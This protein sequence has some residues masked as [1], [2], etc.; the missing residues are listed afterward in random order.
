MKFLFQA[1]LLLLP[2]TIYAESAEEIRA[3]YET[4]RRDGF[5]KVHEDYV[6]KLKAAQKTLLTSQQLE[7]ANAIQPEIE[8]VGGRVELFK[9]GENPAVPGLIPTGEDSG[10]QSTESTDVIRSEETE[11]LRGEFLDR[12]RRGL[13][14]INELY[15]KKSSEAQ[16]VR[17]A[18]ADLTGANALE[19][20]KSELKT[21]LD[22]ITGKSPLPGG[23]LAAK[24]DKGDDLLAGE[25]RKR[26]VEVTGNWEFKSGSLVGAGNSQINYTTKIRAPFVLTFDF[27]VKK[28]MRPRIYVGGKDLKIANEGYK[29]QI[30][31]YPIL[32]KEEPVPYEIGKKYSVKFVANRRFL[33]LYLDDKLV[34]KRDTGLEEEIE[35]IGFLGGDDFSPGTTEFSNIRLE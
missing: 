3:A 9:K 13:T 22:A 7:A 26:W 24:P 33:E 2:C 15:Y 28:G 31:L 20:L 6:T 5:I 32:G 23:G 16:K 14:T 27:E 34:T 4:M 8:Q 1:L 10:N 29:N 30:G 17:M 11:E 21:E 19:A 25:F 18:A 12:L 35:Y